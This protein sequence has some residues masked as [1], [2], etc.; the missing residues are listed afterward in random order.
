MHAACVMPDAPCTVMTSL[1]ADPA[2][3][4]AGCFAAVAAPGGSDTVPDIFVT[5]H[6]PD[7]VAAIVPL[8]VWVPLGTLRTIKPYSLPAGAPLATTNERTQGPEEHA[9][10]LSSAPVCTG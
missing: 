9:V 8:T 3:P 4:N 7:C 1:E 2:V 5:S 6:V 10:E